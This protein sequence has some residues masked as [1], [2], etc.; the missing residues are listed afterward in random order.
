MNFVVILA[1]NLS[2]ISLNFDQGTYE[3][4]EQSNQLLK[5][6]LVVSTYSTIFHIRRHTEDP[7]NS[8]QI[9]ELMD[10]KHGLIDA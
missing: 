3:Q 6:N 10:E 8:L 7:Q 9:A 4:T 5:K 2:T 1:T